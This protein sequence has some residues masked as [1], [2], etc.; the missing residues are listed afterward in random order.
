[1]C[2]VPGGIT[3]YDA[4]LYSHGAGVHSYMNAETL[5]SAGAL[6][7]FIRAIAPL[8]I[9]VAQAVLHHI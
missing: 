9:S 6:R 8:R 2:L 3:H 1:M 7:G 5:I 4:I